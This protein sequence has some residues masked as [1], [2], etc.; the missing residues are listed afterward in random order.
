M[1]TFACHDCGFRSGTRA[2]LTYHQRM[3]KCGPLKPNCDHMWVDFGGLD[4][5][6]L[7]GAN[8]VGD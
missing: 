5:C 2:G 6:K 4:Q 8:R 1:R 3:M 7:C